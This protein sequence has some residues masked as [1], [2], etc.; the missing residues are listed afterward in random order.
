KLELLWG[1][2]MGGELSKPYQ[3][4]IALLLGLVGRL[5]TEEIIPD[6]PDVATS[7]RSTVASHQPL[8][9]AVDAELATAGGARRAVLSRVLEVINVIDNQL[10]G[11]ESARRQFAVASKTLA[12]LERIHSHALQARRAT[13]QSIVERLATL[14]NEFYEFIHPG[15]KIDRKSGV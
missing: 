11:L 12:Q 6:L 4:E 7:L 14:A 3:D 8:I 2:T 15:E 9:D 5:K 1:K 10:A 13:V